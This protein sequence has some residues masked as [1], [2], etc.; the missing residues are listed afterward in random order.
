MKKMVKKGFTLTELIVVVA[1]FSIIMVA[2]MSL[3]DPVSNI[4]KSTALAERT[5]SNANSIQTYVQTQLEYAESMVVATSN[6]IGDGAGGVSSD[7]LQ[8]LVEEYG[9]THF[10]YIVTGKGR[11]GAE[12]ELDSVC[13]TN[14]NIRVLR[15]VN[16]GDDRGQVM[17]SIYPFQSNDDS[18]GGFTLV[19]PSSVTE[20]PMINPAFFQARD[21]RYNYTYALGTCRFVNV[22]VPTGGDS[23]STYRAL[24]L[25]FNG[26]APNVGRANLSLSIV[27]DKGG[28][29]NRGSIDVAADDGNIY[30]AFRSPA[31]IQSAPISLT[32]I[33]TK[34][35][36]YKE[37][38]D[39]GRRRPIILNGTEPIAYQST[40]TPEAVDGCGWSYISKRLDGSNKEL[41][42]STI[43]CTEDIYFI[44]AYTDEMEP[45]AA[46]S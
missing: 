25:D 5:Y 18:N 26:L 29:D 40:I 27:I 33:N 28:K 45:G 6:N 4:Y 21:A 46:V 34:V 13:W 43:D 11:S 44:Y 37:N 30:R 3:I 14:G 42:S 7:E 10:N 38:E 31:T 39:I 32:N 20:E 2:V 8:E 24:D 23:E 12:S 41:I 1:I 17:E 16:S 35:D 19:N 36:F 9:R 15:L 22:P